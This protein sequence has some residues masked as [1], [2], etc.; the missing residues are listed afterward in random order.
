MYWVVF[1]VLRAIK[2][3]SKM[4]VFGYLF[5]CLSPINNICTFWSIEQLKE[6][7]M[8]SIV[9]SRRVAAQSGLSSQ[10]WLV[11]MLGSGANISSV[12]CPQGHP[13][14][15]RKTVVDSWET[16]SLFSLRI[17]SSNFG[18]PVFG[19]KLI[20]RLTN[21]QCTQS[22]LAPAAAQYWRAGTYWEM[23]LAV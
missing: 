22:S 18:I 11:R 8:T 20:R 16:I 3:R 7:D 19:G 14:V 2:A 12:L 13:S 1:E 6:R 15:H 17:N 5:V 10:L 23:Q 21:S 4:A 9:S